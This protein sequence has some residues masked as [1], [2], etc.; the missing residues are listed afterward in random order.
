[1]IMSFQESMV[2]ELNGTTLSQHAKI[3][4]QRKQVSCQMR[5]VCGLC[6]NPS[7]PRVC[8]SFNQ[9]FMLK[10]FPQNGKVIL[11]Q[12]QNSAQDLIMYIRNDEIVSIALKATHANVKTM[13]GKHILMFSLSTDHYMYK[14][15]INSEVFDAYS[16]PR[17]GIIRR[18]FEKC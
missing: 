6:I 14:Q 15:S 4:M 18:K 8:L 10:I 17:F 11:L 2:A 12:H 9:E 1:M 13:F 5:Q 3:V 7:D 16:Q